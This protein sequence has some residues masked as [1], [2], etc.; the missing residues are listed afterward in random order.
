MAEK[1][2]STTVFPYLRASYEIFIFIL[3]SLK[4][5]SSVFKIQGYTFPP[6]KYGFVFICSQPAFI[7]TFNC[8][9]VQAMILLYFDSIYLTLIISFEGS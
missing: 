9:I 7:L 5:R 1:N 3:K 6:I 2:N 4:L 8:V